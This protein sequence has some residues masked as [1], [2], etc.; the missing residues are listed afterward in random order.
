MLITLH[1]GD[2]I[3]MVIVF[4]PRWRCYITLIIGGNIKNRINKIEKMIVTVLFNIVVSVEVDQM[5]NQ[6]AITLQ[7]LPVMPEIAQLK[8]ELGI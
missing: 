7:N 3:T 2:I 5:L 4:S 6:S 8:L 1:C